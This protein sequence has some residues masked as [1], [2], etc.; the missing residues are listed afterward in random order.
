MTDFHKPEDHGRAFALLFDSCT[1]I[2]KKFKERTSLPYS[3]IKDKEEKRISSMLD[4]ASEIGA[5]FIHLQLAAISAVAIARTVDEALLMQMGA[6]K[7]IPNGIAICP[8][9]LAKA[10]QVCEENLIVLKDIQEATKQ[11]A[12]V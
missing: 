11:Y 5:Q 3:M 4:T 7:I 10:I 2:E 8:T 9:C 12:K 1:D 6:I